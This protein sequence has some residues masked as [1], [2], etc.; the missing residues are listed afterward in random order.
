MFRTTVAASV[1]AGAMLL[2]SQAQAAV[3][4]INA[5]ALSENFI[6]LTQGTPQEPLA[7]GETPAI[8]AYDDTSTLRDVLASRTTDF[9]FAQGGVDLVEAAITTS[10][11]RIDFNSAASGVMAYDGAGYVN[12]LEGPAFGRLGAYRS[13][14]YTFSVNR[15]SDLNL[16]YSNFREVRL[17][18]VDT[19]MSFIIT[20]LG[21]SGSQF[22][23]LDAGEYVLMAAGNG[24]DPWLYN[25]GPDGNLSGSYHAEVAFQITDAAIPEPTSWALMIMGFGAAGAMLRRRTLA[26]A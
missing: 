6:Q 13:A 12:I 7:E 19:G 23:G 15:A 11:T 10:A 16:T 2:T 17:Y 21:G 26:L 18:R 24:T 20:Q 14:N 25:A 5:S 22:I 3:T 4:F 1:A 8:T 9:T